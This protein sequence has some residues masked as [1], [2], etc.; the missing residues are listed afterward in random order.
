MIKSSLY[1]LGYEGTFFFEGDALLFNIM[2]QLHTSVFYC[3]S[4]SES[5]QRGINPLF[6]PYH[7]RIEVLLTEFATELVRTGYHSTPALVPFGAQGEGH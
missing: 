6:A 5:Y 2:Y 1:S 7:L 3:L 4:L